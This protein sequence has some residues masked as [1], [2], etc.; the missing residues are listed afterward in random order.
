VS[1]S[2]QPSFFP[3]LRPN[4][5]IAIARLSNKGDVSHRPVANPLRNVSVRPMGITDVTALYSFA[6]IVGEFFC[7]ASGR[8]ESLIGRLD[9]L[10]DRASLLSMP[11]PFATRIRVE[12]ARSAFHPLLLAWRSRPGLRGSTH[13]AS[14]LRMFYTDTTGNTL[15]FPRQ[16]NILEADF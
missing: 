16:P 8:S 5:Q 6:D 10:K 13:T 2:D 14:R 3:T 11:T 15:K 9:W 12:V 1:R 7:A 4:R